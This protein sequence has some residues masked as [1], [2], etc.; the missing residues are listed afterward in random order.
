MTTQAVAKPHASIV[1]RAFAL[2]V[3]GLLL[4][5]VVG[6]FYRVLNNPNL[7]GVVSFAV[8]AA[9]Q[10]YFL[11]RHHGQTPGKMLLDI[12]VVKVD[13]SPLTR[14]D[15]FIRYL[16]YA[17]NGLSLGLGWLWA[18]FDKDHQG[19]HDKVAKTYVVNVQRVALDEQDGSEV[20]PPEKTAP[21]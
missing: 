1:S 10:V 21:S 20:D 5:L 8:G 13:G 19:W 17:I 2:L 16:G 18:F 11:A 9:F 3:D 6:A 15:A 4:S 7:E 12:R 14:T